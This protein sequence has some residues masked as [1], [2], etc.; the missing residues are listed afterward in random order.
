ME[1]I[2]AFRI[3]ARLAPQL[4]RVHVYLGTALL[5]VDDAAGAADALKRAV[6]LD[7]TDVDA[8][9]RLGVALDDIEDVDGAVNAFER[10]IAIDP[11]REEARQNLAIVRSRRGVR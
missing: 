9:N 2:D 7:S 6:A 5:N 4:A 3:S 1:A 10:A 8:W 11:A